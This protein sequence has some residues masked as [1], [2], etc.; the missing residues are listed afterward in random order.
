MI[1]NTI[2]DVKWSFMIK[3]KYF[4]MW[5]K[6]LLFEISNSWNASEIDETPIRYVVW[7][8][9]MLKFVAIFE[10][11]WAWDQYQQHWSLFWGY[12][13]ATGP[14]LNTSNE[15]KSEKNYN[16]YSVS[17][18]SNAIARKHISLCAYLHLHVY[19]IWYIVYYKMNC[20]SASPC[21]SLLAQFNCVSVFLFF[22]TRTNARIHP[23]WPDCT[24]AQ[25]NC[26]VDN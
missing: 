17:K 23:W 3:Q 6:K 20:F 25:E 11:R 2:F 19:N 10:P 15:H 9:K 7:I 1:L 5:E 8:N 16:F 26:T 12:S 18:A 24:G 22:C 4:L 21:Q 13:H 14:C